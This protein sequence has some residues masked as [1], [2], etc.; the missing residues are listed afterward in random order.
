MSVLGLQDGNPFKKA[1]V[2]ENLAIMN[3][4]D[5]FLKENQMFHSGFE[6]DSVHVKGFLGDP[7]AAFHDFFFNIPCSLV[8]KFLVSFELIAMSIS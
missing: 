8:Q 3:H 1:K 4:M 7:R 5:S 2:L 6:L